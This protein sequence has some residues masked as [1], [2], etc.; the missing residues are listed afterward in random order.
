[1]FKEIL[2]GFTDLLFP[3]NCALC[4]AYD[5]STAE[6]PLCQQC[7]TTIP[8]NH[9]PFCLRCSR[10]INRS[11][12]Q[13]LCPDCIQQYPDFD[14]AWVFTRYQPPMTELIRSFK[15]HNKTSLRKTFHTIANTFA[16]RHS[17][18]LRADLLLP[19]PIHP[20]RFRE[21]SYNQSEL[22]AEIVSDIFHIP[23]NIN[24]LTKMLLTPRQSDLRRKERWTNIQGAFKIEN[25]SIIKNKEIILVDD[26]LTTGATASEAAKTLKQAGAAK[27]K[28]IALS[29]A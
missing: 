9:P 6:Q 25:S 3:L 23:V 1:M 17:L 24:I 11:N 4:G 2:H 28:L 18:E 5:P 12:E 29:A 21:R 7:L 10:H 16:E 8:Y 26:L 13:G 20:V 27:V 15:F 19:I 22:L 14:D